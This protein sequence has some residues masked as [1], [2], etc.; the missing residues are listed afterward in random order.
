MASPSEAPGARSKPRSR[1]GTGLDDRSASAAVELHG[2]PG[3]QHRRARRA[4]PAVDPTRAGE[5]SSALFRRGFQHDTI[6]VG[7]RVDG[8]DLALAEGIVQCSSIACIVTPRRP[9]L[10]RSSDIGDEPAVDLFRRDIAQRRRSPSARRPALATTRRLGHVSTR[11]RVLVARTAVCVDLHVLHRLE[12][13]GRAGDGRDLALSR[14]MIWRTFDCRLLRGL[15]MILRLPTFC[16]ALSWPTPT[17]E[18]T[19]RHLRIVRDDCRHLALQTG[20]FGKRD[21]RSAFDDCRDGAGVLIRK[22]ALRHDDVEPD[23][24][25]DRDQETNS[26]AG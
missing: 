8:R 26:V 14:S 13:H 23:R 11:Q 1:P 21:L 22:E 20:H 19:R 4:W 12:M 6:L 25:D 18:A 24:D 15:S 3:Q 7:L 10:S 2:G 5:G 9:A 16:V 17:I